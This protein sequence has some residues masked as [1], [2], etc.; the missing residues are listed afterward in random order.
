[1]RPFELFK[2]LL[3]GRKRYRWDK[4]YVSG[5]W[6]YLNETAVAESYAAVLQVIARNLGGERTI[7]ELGCGEGILQARMPGDTYS[8]FLGI[9]ISRVAI[10]KAQ[11]LRDEK[12]G[13][14]VGNMETYAP[15]GRWDMI[16]F[17][18]VLFYADDPVR[19]VKR[20]LPY[21]RPTGTLLVA[22]R[23]TPDSLETM[24][25]LEKEFVVLD[26]QYAENGRGA[27]HCKLYSQVR[28]GTPRTG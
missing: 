6:D 26:Q 21:L 16:V 9:D 2:K 14:R 23:E 8:R 22:L 20:Y 13:Y 25:A 17:N 1:M 15:P 10:R 18:E 28:P 24:Q 7:L 4:E 5:R 19:L 11:R 12:T 3:L 27:W